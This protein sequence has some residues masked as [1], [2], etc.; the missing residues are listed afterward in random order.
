MNR[1]N[2]C[3]E[4]IE[5]NQVIFSLPLDTIQLSYEYGKEMS[6]TWADMI[7]FDFEHYPFDTV[8]LSKFMKGLRENGPTPS[9]HPTPTVITTLPAN[10]MTP[11]EVLYNAWQIR[12]VLS[13]GIHGILHTHTRREDAVRVFVAASRYVHQTIGRDQG[14]PEGLRGAGGHI[15]AAHI[16]G[17]NHADYFSKADPWPLNPNGELMLGLK[18]EDRFCLQDADNIAAV[19]GISFAEWGPGDMGMSHGDPNSHDPPYTSTMEQARKI[20]KNAC[21]KSN[22]SFLCSWLDPAMS[23]EERVRHV[24]FNI[25][26]KIIHTYDANLANT[27]RREMGRTM[28]W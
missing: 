13:T 11:E 23:E 24:I 12:H 19:P 2:K 6:Q 3:I 22:V 4:L 15:Q 28:P 20:V 16:W 27:L 17:L 9:G 1:I 8:G 5:T 25:G 10:C 7:Q 26:A 18:I 21:A 14:I